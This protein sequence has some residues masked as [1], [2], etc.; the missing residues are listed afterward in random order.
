MY[1]ATWTAIVVAG[2]LGLL[3]GCDRHPKQEAKALQLPQGTPKRPV[4]FSALKVN[5]GAAEPFT[6]NDVAGYFAEHNLPRNRGAK[7]YIQVADLEFITSK[8]ASERL[9][10]EPTGLD[11]SHQVGFATLT[12]TFVFSGPPNAKPAT[13][14]KAY[15][16]FD[17]ETGNLLMDGTL[18]GER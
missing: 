8:Q 18:D 16:L 15:A 5:P 13:F 6:K 3:A 17:A 9:A 4:G 12:G 10:G 1:H 11:D 2:T 14:A 7:T